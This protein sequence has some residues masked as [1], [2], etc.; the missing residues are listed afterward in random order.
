MYTRLTKQI[1]RLITNL[2]L[3]PV[4][5]S[6][7]IE[8][9]PLPPTDPPSG[10]PPANPP[11]SDPPPADDL[12]A[13]FT[14]EE[15]QGKKEAIAQGKAEEERRA[16]LSDD[17]RAAED[18]EKEKAAK[19]SGGAPEAYEDFT[20]PAGLEAAKDL[21]EEFKPFLKTEL[22]LSQDKA[23]KLVD[24]YTTKILPGMQAKGIAASTEAWNE[25]L[26]QRVN[27]I[28]A[29]KEIGGDKYET[30]TAEVNRV[31]NTFLSPEES[32]ELM[33]YFK[34]FGDC[35]P[36]LKLLVRTGSAMKEGSI[37]MSGTGGGGGEAKKSHA[38]RI[39]G[40]DKE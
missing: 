3:F 24:F 30:S 7:A 15:I 13:L 12:A 26:A 33:E 40:N 9:D 28:K 10:D 32:T 4:L 23:Q 5:F 34:R 36:F 17:E 35:K 22:N 20:I 37:V 31:A 6:F 19:E 21:L 38:D 27:D 8:G 39:F 1:R 14:P 2:L 11:P 29:D 25:D 16:A 18:L